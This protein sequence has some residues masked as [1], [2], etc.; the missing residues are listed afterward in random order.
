MKNKVF[1][2]FFILLI[3]ILLFC[4]SVQADVIDPWEVFHEYTGIDKFTEY[5]RYTGIGIVVLAISLVSILSLNVLN[6]TNGKEKSKNQK[7]SFILK[8][9]LNISMIYLSATSINFFGEYEIYDYIE[10]RLVRV[11][12]RGAIICAIIS[13]I[14]LIKNR[15]KPKFLNGITVVITILTILIVAFTYFNTSVGYYT[16]DDSYMDLLDS[17]FKEKYNI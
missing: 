13:I 10:R 8:L 11:I 5:M 14:L 6:K 12:V 15:E 3:F 7:S 17:F 4:N 2:I 16:Y 1:K 9:I